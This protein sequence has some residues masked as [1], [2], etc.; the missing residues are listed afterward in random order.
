MKVAGGWLTS[1]EGAGSDQP[2]VEDLA[3]RWKEEVEWGGTKLGEGFLQHT[4]VRV[5]II[6]RK[7][8]D[9]YVTSW[10]QSSYQGLH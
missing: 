7:K 2:P 8:E 4:W 10:L 3:G 1:P 6:W 9:N 5:G